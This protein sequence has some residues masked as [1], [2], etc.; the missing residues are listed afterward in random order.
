MRDNLG[1]TTLRRRKRSAHPM[2]TYDT[3]PRPLRIWI[4]SA[5]LPW[6]PAS[7]RRIWH[8]ARK[9]GLSADDAVLRMQD[10]EAKNL[11]RDRIGKFSIKH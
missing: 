11:A 1:E 6:S 7:C 10:V 9:E 8:K 3:L 2:Q 4:A 5:A